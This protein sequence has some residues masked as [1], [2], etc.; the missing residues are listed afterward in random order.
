MKALCDRIPSSGII[1]IED[2]LDVF[3][4]LCPCIY[5]CVV[6]SVASVGV[7]KSASPP[8]KPPL[9]PDHPLFG[10]TVKSHTH[11][12][13]N[14][15]LIQYAWSLAVGADGMSGYSPGNIGQ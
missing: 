7:T 1:H 5:V 14:L 11:T 13:N 4:Y 3:T 6:Y 9:L 10:H 12:G 8:S 2:N 15:L